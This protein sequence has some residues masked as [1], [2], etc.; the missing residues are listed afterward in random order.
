MR[1]LDDHKFP[2]EEEA[3]RADSYLIGRGITH[4]V[5]V[6]SC[7]LGGG[8][9]PCGSLWSSRSLLRRS[10]PQIQFDASVTIREVRK[11]R[12]DEAMAS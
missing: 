6:R 10:R 8:P 11:F 4:K 5:T 9:V 7:R 1:L 2:Q 3:A 12:T